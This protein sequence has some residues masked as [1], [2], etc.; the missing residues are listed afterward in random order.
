MGTTFLMYLRP[1]VLMVVGLSGCRTIGLSDYRVV[2][3]SGC[4]TIGSSDYRAVGIL[5]LNLDYT[6][7]GII[8]TPT[9]DRG[10]LQSIV[11]FV[12]LDRKRD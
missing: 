6:K 9:G 4:R 8:Y 7:T 3:L 10:I 12:L 11:V 1:S 2:G 5:G